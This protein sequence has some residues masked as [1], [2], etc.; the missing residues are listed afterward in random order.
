[1]ISVLSDALYIFLRFNHL[2]RMG[3][4]LHYHR[5]QERLAEL[6]GMELWHQLQEQHPLGQPEAQHPLEGMEQH[7]AA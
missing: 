2:L 4:R 5:Q 3:D 6:E 1:M 7:L